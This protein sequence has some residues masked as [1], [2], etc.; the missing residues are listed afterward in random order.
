[1]KTITILGVEYTIKY[2][3]GVIENDHNIN[4]LCNYVNK[5]I[6]VTTN[7]DFNKEEILRHEVVHAFLYESGLGYYASD[8]NLVEWIAIQLPK[9]IKALDNIKE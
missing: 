6:L 4:G 1:M 5:E 9:I 7:P 3:D 2:V 8:E